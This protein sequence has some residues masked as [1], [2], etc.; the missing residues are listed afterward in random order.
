MQREEIIMAKIL[1]VEEEELIGMT[2]DEMFACIEEMLDSDELT[3]PNAAVRAE[4]ETFGDFLLQNV[5]LIDEVVG[6]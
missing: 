2:E 5:S 6:V 3:S 1:S 4:N